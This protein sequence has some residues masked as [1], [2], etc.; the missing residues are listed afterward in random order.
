VYSLLLNWANLHYLEAAACSFLVAVT[1]NYLWNRTWTFR[2]ERGHIGY[3]GLRF[4][5]VSVVA[6][7][8][9]LLILR[10]LVAAGLGKIVAQAIADDGGPSRA[11]VAGVLTTRELEVL[12]L[13]AKLRTDRQIGDELFISRSTVSRHIEHILGKLDVNTRHEAV[14]ALHGVPAVVADAA[15]PDPEVEVVEHEQADLIDA[16]LAALPERQR[17]IISRHFE[18]GRTP[19]EIAD[20]AAA[21]HLSQQRTRTIERD[22][23]YALRERLEPAP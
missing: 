14:A 3:Q 2:G 12:R 22:A 6:L 10:G 18:F 4:L 11:A 15:A 17:E 16:A 20:V 8:A 7:G 21:L 9:N 5:I 23:L 1:N 13:A 19:E